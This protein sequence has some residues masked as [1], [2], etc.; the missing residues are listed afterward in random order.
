MC[1]GSIAPRDPGETERVL[2][3]NA[4]GPK[5][6][7]LVLRESEDGGR[8][9]RDVAVLAGGHAAYSDTLRLP[10]GTFGCLYECGDAHAYERLSLVRFR[11]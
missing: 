7:R 5:R 11:V 8:T 2:L 6:E 9:F 1:Q 4:A 3:V 10:D